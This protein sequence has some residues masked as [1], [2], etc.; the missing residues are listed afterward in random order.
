MSPLD[1]LGGPLEP[2]IIPAT[3]APRDLYEDDKH[4]SL[5]DEWYAEER[6]WMEDFREAC[7]HE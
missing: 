1:P 2:E 5:R 7:R 3:E 6:E 4:S